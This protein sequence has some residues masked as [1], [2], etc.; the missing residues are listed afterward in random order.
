M[1]FPIASLENHLTFR[2]PETHK[3]LAIEVQNGVLERYDCEPTNN[4]RSNRL[5]GADV[6]DI[7]KSAAQSKVTTGA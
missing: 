4:T 2:D 5:F 1:A 3:I 7:S 6:S